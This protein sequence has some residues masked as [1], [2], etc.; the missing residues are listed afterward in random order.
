MGVFHHKKPIV[1][2]GL[3]FSVDAFNE[4]SYVSGD[5]T[6]ND[7]T[8]TT[9]G[10]TLNNGVGYD[11][12]TWTFDGA[13]DYINFGNVFNDVFAGADKK[14]TITTWCEFDF[15]STASTR[16]VV[17][18]VGASGHIPPEN[19]RMFSVYIRDFNGTYGGFEFE[20]LT[21]FTLTSDSF[22]SYRTVGADIQTGQTYELTI[23]YDG[24]IDGSGRYDL[25][26]NGEQY[27][28]TVTFSSGGWGNM[29]ASNARLSFGAS[30]GEASSPILPMN[31]NISSVKIYNRNL[32]S[33]EVKQNYDAT[34][35]RFI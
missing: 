34:K 20:F 9:T 16:T 12:N 14:F 17:D 15:L 21:Y 26:V 11:T 27:P 31:G 23:S 6:C 25:Y 28:T 4:L 19:E 18:K 8:L 7:M 1:R 32:S 24:S 10:G 30:I 2:D 29:Q 13:N 3:V 22:A 35:Y 5:T 33:H